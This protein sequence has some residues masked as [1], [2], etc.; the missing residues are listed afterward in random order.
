VADWVAI[1]PGGG[2]LDQSTLKA[3]TAT[4]AAAMAITT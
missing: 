4:T 3:T 1:A 2:G